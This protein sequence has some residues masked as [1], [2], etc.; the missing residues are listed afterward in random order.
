MKGFVFSFLFLATAFIAKAQTADEIINKHIEAIGGAD[1]WKK[2][3]S[4]KQEGT[5]ELEGTTV[6]MS[7]TILN[8]KGLRQDFS[9]VGVNGFIVITP[10]TGWNFMP[11]PGQEKPIPMSESEIND[12]QSFLDVQGAFIDYELKGHTVSYEG[13]DKVNGVDCFILKL[14]LKNGETETIFID[15]STYLIIRTK[16]IIAYSFGRTFDLSKNSPKNGTRLNKREEKNTDYSNYE[17]V[18]EGILMPKTVKLPS[19]EWKIRK[20]TIN[21]AINESIFRVK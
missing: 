9:V 19:G 16:R 13:K 15:T 4:I 18:P 6:L 17:K 10:T 8:G 21:D 3:N 14:K 11:L 7:E 20:I 12:C 2:V 5:M 1:A